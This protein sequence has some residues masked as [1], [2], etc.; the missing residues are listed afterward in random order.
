[1][2]FQKI[3]PKERKSRPWFFKKFFECV[4]VLENRKLE[5]QKSWL[6]FGFYF[7]KLVRKNHN[8]RFFFRIFYKKQKNHGHRCSRIAKILENEKIVVNFLKSITKFCSQNLKIIRIL[9]ESSIRAWKERTQFSWLLVFCVFADGIS[10]KGK[11]HTCLTLFW[12]IF[13]NKLRN[14]FMALSIQFEKFLKI[15]LAKT[16]QNSF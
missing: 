6:S 7:P 11:D 16:V 5:N 14:S 4:K 9:F 12:D 1:M 2:F 13:P 3:P 10:R 15:K 8:W